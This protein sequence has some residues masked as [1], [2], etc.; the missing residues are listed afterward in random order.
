MTTATEIANA[1]VAVTVKAPHIG[2]DLN[3]MLNGTD[4][5][6]QSKGKI[7]GGV[8]TGAVAG[9]V[10]AAA[11]KAINT[12]MGSIDGAI[13]RVDTLNNFPK[14]MANLGYSA[15]DAKA[16]IDKISKSLIGLPT[17]LDGMAGA[18]QQLAPLTNGLGEATD[19][20]LALNNALLAGGKSTDIQA[21]A[22]EQYVQQLAVGKV[23]MTAWRS[24]VSAMP[25]QMDQLSKSLLGANAKQ[26][27]LYAAMQSGSVTFDQFNAA[28]LSLNKDGY[29]GFASFADQ[30]KSATDGIATSQSNLQTA[31]TRT[32]ATIIQKFQPA[33]ISTTG[34]IT[35]LVNSIGP[36]VTSMIDG[37][38]A[39]WNWVVANKGWITTVA[40][41]A[42]P[43][44]TLIGAVTAARV[45][46][47][48]W[49][50]ITYGAAG[51]SYASGLALKIYTVAMNAQSFA[52]KV[53][54]G[55]Q[56]AF[57]AVMNANPIVRVVTI[58]SALV[59][60]LVVFFTQTKE[61]KAIWE[62][63]TRFLGEAWANI[64]GFFTEAWENVI[65]PVFKAIGDIATWVYES[66]LKPVF[67]GIAAVVGF[68]AGMFKVQFDLIVIAFRLVGA[69]ATWLWENGIQPAFQAIGAIVS[70]LW[71]SI[72][73]PYI[74]AWAALFQW[75][76]STVL[77][78]VFGFIGAAVQAVGA[79][80]DW[81][82]KNVV[83][84]VWTGISNA[85]GTAWNWINTNVF[86]PMKTGI[87][88]VGK[89]FD[90]VG[91][92]IGE[93]WTN[94]QNAAK[95][96]VKFLINTVW[97]DGI[98]SFAVDVL[99]ALGMGDVAK[100]LPRVTV[101]FANGGVLPGY[102][103]GRDVHQF[104]SPTAGGL[105]LSGGEA[106]MR[107]EFTRLVGGPAGVDALNAAARKG[108]LPIGDGEGNFFGDAWDAISKAASVAWEFLSNPAQ[109]IKQHLTGFTSGLGGNGLLSD[110]ASGVPK[111][112][113]RGL[114]NV[115][116]NAAPKG[117][118]SKGMGWE[119]MWNI[120]RSQVPG[121]VKTS[122]FRPGAKTVN[123]GQS[124]HS[125]G[126]AIDIVPASM[127]TFD[128][129]AKLFPNASELIYTPAGNRQLQN[130][131]P[132][133]GW[134][135]AVKKQ[136]YNHVHLAM[137]QG[138]VVPKLYDQGGWLP[139]GGMAVNRSG[140]PEPVFTNDQWSLLRDGFGAGGMEITGR[141]EIGGDGLA[142]I[143]DGR[144]QKKASADAVAYTSGRTSA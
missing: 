79:A 47:T 16:S 10:A 105:A 33:I 130:G 133:A 91:R 114:E 23:D 125:L 27:D 3:N 86:T 9:A 1:Y 103:P 19:L 110:I 82:F 4:S 83:Q 34:Y 129:V 122:D 71:S 25:G 55:A 121:A 124:Y 131:K 73:Q 99:N 89:A 117:V 128:A 12:V 84:P 35:A 43:F 59:A 96:P 21:N 17:T 28:I 58:L 72:I 42:A 112:L 85:I 139:D 100:N 123:G 63:F 54:A 67:D 37:A 50:A 135:D 143:I 92:F 87:D 18:V 68:L 29:A 32:L 108:A 119:A 116:T 49:T 81:F 137:A 136:H 113:L 22:M 132:F 13:K 94:I 144:I 53:A 51:A 41:I 69:I 115:F 40:A 11:S 7:W 93:V 44:A 140:K 74:N 88:A 30:A 141:L 106:I 134:S 90:A 52:T 95:V 8:L 39:V 62:E 126:R 118:G 77:S 2:R 46:T 78:P 109:A 66:V 111:M 26:T 101:P 97:N 64:S 65:Q 60:G 75:L 57:N 36:F 6:F 20:S 138:G 31:I 24:M 102:T 15:D 14:I 127:A 120:V 104:W 70:W 98:R 80:F 107:P 142:R 45:V 48:A 56:A 76:W 5:I 61:G 38:A